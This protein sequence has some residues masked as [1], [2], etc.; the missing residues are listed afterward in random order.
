[1]LSISLASLN[2]WL[3]VMDDAKRALDV[4]LALTTARGAVCVCGSIYLVG[5]ALEHPEVQ[6]RRLAARRQRSA[7]DPAI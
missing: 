2:G 7:L 4:A 3:T 1:M 6:K 5:A